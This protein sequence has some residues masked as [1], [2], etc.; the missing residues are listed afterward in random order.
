MTTS[1]N[2][3]EVES[4]V[5][6]LSRD[7]NKMYRLSGTQKFELPK[8][9]VIIAQVF[10]AVAKAKRRFAVQAWGLADATLE[11][12]FIKLARGAKAFNMLS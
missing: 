12:V 3:K 9:E 8:Q 1:S 2:H 7:A 11:D 6:N 5:N 10:Q 4:L